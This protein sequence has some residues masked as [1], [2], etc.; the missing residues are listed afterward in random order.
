MYRFCRL[1]FLIYLQFIIDFY[2]WNFKA[3]VEEGADN[4]WQLFLWFCSN[5]RLGKKCKK[6][7]KNQNVKFITALNILYKKSF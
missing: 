6:V 4:F 2:F 1:H 3:E 7:R 5:I